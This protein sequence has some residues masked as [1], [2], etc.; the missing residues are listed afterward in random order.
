M[1]RKPTLSEAKARMGLSGKQ[2][3][4]E[5]GIHSGT[6]S[7][8]ENGYRPLKPE[9]RTKLVELLGTFTDPPRKSENL[10]REVNRQRQ[11][12][13]E[14]AI[15]QRTVEQEIELLSDEAIVRVGQEYVEL[16]KFYPQVPTNAELAARNT[17]LREAVRNWLS[18]HVPGG[19]PGGHSAGWLDWATDNFLA[20]PEIAPHLM[21][22]P[23]TNAEL[24]R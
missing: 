19:L 21:E 15:A 12:V 5:L 11:N 16:D 3:A 24:W 6:F 2:L 9:H 7:K 18:R 14:A 23:L 1:S 17:P 20:D 4:K 10:Q 8:I 22:K 13:R